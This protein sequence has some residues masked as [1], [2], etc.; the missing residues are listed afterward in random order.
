[1]TCLGFYCASDDLLL[2][3]AQKGPTS[4]NYPS[5]ARLTK[6]SNI[7]LYVCISLQM[8]GLDQ[9]HLQLLGLVTYQKKKKKLGRD[10]RKRVEGAGQRV[11]LP[12]RPCSHLGTYL[13]AVSNV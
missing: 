6:S 3:S 5:L 12:T 2:A 13:W 9:H 7:T 4:K 11:E 1:M 8:R 10:A